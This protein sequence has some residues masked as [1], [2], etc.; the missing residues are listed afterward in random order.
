VAVVTE[1]FAD[2]IRIAEQNVHHR[3]WPDGA[4]YAREIPARLTEDGAYWVRCSFSDASI[5]G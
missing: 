2:R 4:D 5:L 1:V 3:V